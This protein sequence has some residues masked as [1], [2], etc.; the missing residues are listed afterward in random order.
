M[1]EALADWLEAGK[2]KLYCVESNVAEAWT[3]KDSDPKWRIQRHQ[4]YERF[5]SDEL[6]PFIRL[7]PLSC[8]FRRNLRS[9]STQERRMSAGANRRSTSDFGPVLRYPY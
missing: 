2:L 5:L 8:S 3:R 1:V 4:A 6:I 9:A 7:P